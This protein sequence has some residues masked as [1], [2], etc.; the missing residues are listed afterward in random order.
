M[1]MPTQIP[2]C[3]ICMQPV[4]KQVALPCGHLFCGPPRKCVDYNKNSSNPNST[5]CSACRQEFTVPI[6]KF[7]PLVGLQTEKKGLQGTKE[8]TLVSNNLRYNAEPSTLFA[9]KLENLLPVLDVGKVQIR[10]SYDDSTPNGH[11]SFALMLPYD[12]LMSAKLK[13][14]C[15]NVKNL[16]KSFTRSFHLKNAETHSTF[17]FQCK[18]ERDDGNYSMPMIISYKQVTFAAA[19]DSAC[20]PTPKKA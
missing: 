20:A 19:D 9:A 14:T 13:I 2:D 5:R 10:A 4:E 6:E 12:L 18:L 8:L 11:L 7:K 1:A 17:G 3:Y 15:W 16:E